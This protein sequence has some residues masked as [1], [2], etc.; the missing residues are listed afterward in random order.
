MQGKFAFDIQ[1]HYPHMKPA[2]VLIWEAFIRGNPGFFD[3]VDYDVPV[4]EGAPFLPESEEA[5]VS[6]YRLLTQKKID[7]VGY[8]D[9]EV[10]LIEVKPNAGSKALGQILTYEK[11]YSKTNP[12]LTNLRKCVITNFLQPEY[13]SVYSKFNVVVIEV[14]TVPNI[15][16]TAEIP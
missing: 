13:D 11:L 16:V 6:D 8:R 3:S 15:P 4:G 9:N 12:N 10:W 7:V 14:G 2:D 5:F 1:S